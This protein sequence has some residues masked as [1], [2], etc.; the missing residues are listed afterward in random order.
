MTRKILFTGSRD[1][2]PDMLRR[3][4]E[5]LDTLVGMDVHI[6]VGDAEGVD[7]QV[8]CYADELELSIECH[9]AYNRMRFKT[10]TGRNIPH[11]TDYLGRDRIMASLLKEGDTCIAVWNGKN[12]KSG[13]IAT[14]RYA[15]RSGAEIVWLH[16]SP[17]K[18]EGLHNKEK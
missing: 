15:K 17:V 8:V 14:A 12:L 5:Y 7:Y 2:S 6:I 1:A 11:D 3:V 13:T 9:G 18:L 16:K 4:R 10:W